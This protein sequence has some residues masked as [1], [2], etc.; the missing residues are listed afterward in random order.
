MLNK[1]VMLLAFVAFSP[2]GDALNG[3]IKHPEGSCW[4][5]AVIS[6]ERM[7][8]ICAGGALMVA[9]IT[10]M[11]VPKL[12]RAGCVNEALQGF[13]A[14]MELKWI[15]Y[16]AGDIRTIGWHWEG[17]RLYAGI[18]I[19]LQPVDGLLGTRMPAL[20]DARTSGKWC[21]G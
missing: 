1:I 8:F 6:G 19:D 3:H 5:V 16:T 11:D 12:T 14:M 13:R 20:F 10:H 17:D 4:P 7:A 21:E 9:T 2:I 18:L 15:L